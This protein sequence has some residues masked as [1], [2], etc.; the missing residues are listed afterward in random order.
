MP[1]PCSPYGLRALILLLQDQACFLARCGYVGLVVDHY[2]ET[3]DFKYADRN[4]CRNFDNDKL[5]T[6]LSPADL[7][8]DQRAAAR[9]HLRGA[10]DQMHGLLQAP[11]FWRGLMSTF[12][13]TAREHP[14]VHPDKAAAI[15]YCFGGQ[16]CLEQVRAG[17]KLDAIVTFHGLLHSRPA[18]RDETNPRGWGERITQ[19]DYLATIEQA[20]NHYNKDC[21]VLI[22]N[23]DLDHS[24]PIEG[25][26][27]WKQEM[28]EQGIDWRFNNHARTP[29]GFAL[30]PGVWG[31]AY[32]ELADRRSTLSMLSLF[33]EVWPEW[34]QYA[35]PCNACGTVLGQSIQT[36]AKL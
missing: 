19:E 34:P 3:K 4:P 17:D 12:L 25:I 21:K 28:N 20:P 33:A 29:H 23:G 10:F 32:Q 35:V 6:P 15:G 22:E 5:Q 18:Y 1:Y 30:A 13:A 9:R 7:S 26:E 31:S 8:S 36:A 16:A 2:K 14:S 24:V 11:T 27:I